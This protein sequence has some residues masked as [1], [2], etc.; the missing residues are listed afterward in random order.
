MTS[1]VEFTW[2]SIVLENGLE[3]KD[4]K[5]S[6]KNA[7]EWN[8]R[9]CGTSHSKGINKKAIDWLINEK[10]K[11]IIL[12]QGGDDMLLQNDQTTEY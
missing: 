11:Y 5:I 9:L 8:W 7:I 4:A 3:F 10:C 2:G 12:S 6:Y 1:V